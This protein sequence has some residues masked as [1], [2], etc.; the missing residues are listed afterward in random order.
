[1]NTIYKKAETINQK[2]RSY[3]KAA[4]TAEQTSTGLQTSIESKLTIL[5]TTMT[6]I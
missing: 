1:V 6:K 3:A 5:E 4:H 2:K